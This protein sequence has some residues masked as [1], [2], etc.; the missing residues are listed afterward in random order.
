[1][2]NGGEGRKSGIVQK[3]N[4]RMEGWA[5]FK[6]RHPW[7]GSACPGFHP[8]PALPVLQPRDGA[9]LQPRDAWRVCPSLTAW[10]H[11]AAPQ[12][13]FHTLKHARI[14]SRWAL[15]LAW[16][17]WDPADGNARAG[18]LSGPR[19][20]PA[21]FIWPLSFKLRPNPAGRSHGKCRNAHPLERGV[22]QL[23]NPNLDPLERA[24]E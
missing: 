16:G 3:D 2:E 22:F 8:E 17:Q 14:P 21:A 20:I 18:G 19:V 15:P 10:E 23:V 11:R 9:V 6:Q 13:G 5:F 24:Q 7:L 1:M 12:E 4:E